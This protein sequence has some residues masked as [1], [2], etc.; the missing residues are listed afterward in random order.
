MTTILDR[1]KAYKLDEIT[2]RKA[3]RALSEVEEAARNAPAPRG[4]GRALAEAATTGYGLIAEIKMPA[5][6]KVSSAPILIPP[7]LHGR[8]KSVAQP[9]C[10]C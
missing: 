5:R 9:A 3:A 1:I 4:F 2:A 6:P 7:L 8:T 10:P